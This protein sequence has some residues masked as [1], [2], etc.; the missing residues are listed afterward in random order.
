MKGKYKG[1]D[2]EVIKEKCLAGYK[3][4]FFSIFDDGF[5]V[6]SGYSEGEDT[7]KDYYESMKKVIDD[8]KEHPEDYE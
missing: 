5:E 3:M 7:I 1:C 2:I 8:Y 6:T 4:L